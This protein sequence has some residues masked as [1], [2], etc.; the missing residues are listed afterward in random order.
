MFYIL[1]R[2]LERHVAI[3]VCSLML[4]VQVGD[5]SAALSYYRNK[6][7]NAPKWSSPLVSP[8]W[9]DIGKQYK[10]IVYVLPRS[11]LDTYLPWAKFATENRMEI[12]FGYFARSD[13]ERFD[14]ARK[15]VSR[16]IIENEVDPDALYVFEHEGLWKIVLNQAAESDLVGVLDGFR[17]LAPKLKDCVA[18]NRAAM[19]KVRIEDEQAY[20]IGER[21]SFAQGGTSLKY[22]GSGWSGA[23]PWGTWTEGST[24]I[25]ILTPSVV[26]ERDMALSI[27]GQAFLTDKHPVQDI[28]VLVNRHPVETLHYEFPASLDTRVITIP[29]SFIQEKKGPLI[30]EFK[31]KDPK[32]PAE[33]GLSSDT[34]RLGLGLVSLRL[35]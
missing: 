29:K 3:T 15:R 9:A 24:S 20:P 25:V 7:S 31:I 21:I 12:N 8:L 23:E 18:C 30:I 17:I 33:L 16:S 32:S 28:E 6:L 26:P 13:P 11:A 22:A 10:R 4:V 27:E 14:E 2:Q 19:A 34:R 5:M 1:F 35:L